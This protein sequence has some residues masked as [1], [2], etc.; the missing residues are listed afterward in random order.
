MGEAVSCE[1]LLL[2]A[3]SLLGQQQ[4]RDMRL[5]LQ[6]C[7]ACQNFEAAA[8]EQIKK[9]STSSLLRALCMRDPPA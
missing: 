4:H 8:K 9:N 6:H 5:V 7:A 3:P 2:A 1:G